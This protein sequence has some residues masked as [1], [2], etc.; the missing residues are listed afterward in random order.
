MSLQA[1]G[2]GGGEVAAER[3]RGEGEVG[4]WEGVGKGVGTLEY[5]RMKVPF[6]NIGG[7]I[8]IFW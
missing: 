2:G 7:V 3:K 6:P 1:G 4:R 8:L 5:S